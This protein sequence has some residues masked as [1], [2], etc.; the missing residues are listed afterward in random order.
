[1]G[2]II[3]EL[4]SSWKWVVLAK[5]QL[6]CN[7]LHYIHGELQFATHATC[8]LALIMYKYSELQFATQVT[9]SLALIMYKYSELQMSFTTQKLN[10]KASHKT[11]FF[12]YCMKN[13]TDFQTNTLIVFD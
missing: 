2:A 5:L 9:C 4:H 12:S 13:G 8:S 7:E 3:M 1:M 10:C 6:S 11:P